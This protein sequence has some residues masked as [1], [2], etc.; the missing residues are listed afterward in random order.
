MKNIF[1]E[2]ISMDSYEAMTALGKIFDHVK[3]YKYQVHDAV[4]V[5]II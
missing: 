2:T 5:Y 4:E 1:G 3:A